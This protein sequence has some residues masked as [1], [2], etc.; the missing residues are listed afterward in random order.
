MKLLIVAIVALAVVTATAEEAAETYLD[1]IEDP[2]FHFPIDPTHILDRT[3]PW[4]VDLR[5]TCSGKT[6]VADCAELSLSNDEE[7]GDYYVYKSWEGVDRWVMC[8]GYQQ[9]RYRPEDAPSTYQRFEICTGGS[10]GS[11]A[12][13]DEE[14]GVFLDGVTEPHFYFPGHFS[15]ELDRKSPWGTAITG[16]ECDGTLVAD[17]DDLSLSGED[18]CGK[19]YV[20]KPWKGVDRWVICQGIHS[21]RHRPGTPARD[22]SKFEQCSMS[23]VDDEAD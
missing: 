23:E 3:T 6:Q 1:G 11:L 13:S 22:G 14:S 20:Y 2:H 4:T 19:Y 18:S 10:T 17:C 9:C 7:C 12:R 5:S 16:G 15:S 21:C 8:Q